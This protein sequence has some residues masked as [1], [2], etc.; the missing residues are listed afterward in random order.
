MTAE[1]G[2][3]TLAVAGGRPPR[4]TIRAGL[5]GAGFIGEIH[6][7]A[8]RSAGAVLTAVADGAPDRTLVAASRLGAR[9]ALS[10]EDLISSPDVDVVHICTPNHLHAELTRRA[11]RAG[12]HVVCEKP[13]ATTS[14]EAD[15]LAAQ[16]E[17][18]GVVAAVP[19][20]YRYYPMVREARARVLDGSTGPVR[21]IHG[22]YLQ[23]WLSRPGD[24]NWRV[25]PSLGGMSRTFADI[26]IHWCDLVEFVTGH[27]IL[28]LAATLLTSVPIR[29]AVDPA[30]QALQQV[31]TED[32]ATILFETDQRAIGSLVVSQVTPGRKNRLWLSLDGA[33]ASLAFDQEQPESLWMGRREGIQIL[34]RGGEQ[35]S[36]DAGALTVL[37]PGHPQ[38]YQDCF[39][40]FVADVYAAIHGVRAEDM[41]SFAAGR[42]AAALTEAVLASNAHHAWVDVSE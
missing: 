20:I 31:T 7:R 33:E 25:D 3:Y 40:A 16:A 35:L 5:I 23:D 29:P 36:P 41:P 1:S 19:F 27:R 12:K 14:A 32:A 6:A 8:I 42:R 38:G 34:V 26:G 9:A 10:A 18:A 37:P 15:D 28:R 17:L 21:I 39:N 11:I 30:S 22:S 4:A 13:L 2:G 24:R